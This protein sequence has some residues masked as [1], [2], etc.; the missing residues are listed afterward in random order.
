MTPAGR[1]GTISNSSLENPAL[2]LNDPKAWESILVSTAA[3]SGITV[4]H[5]GSLSLAPVWQAVSTISG[6]VAQMPLNVYR[7]LPDGQREV[8]HDH[9]AQYLMTVQPNPAMSAMEL[10]RRAMLHVL[11]WGNAYVYIRRQSRVGPPIELIN[12]LPDRVVPEWASDGTIRYKVRAGGRETVL[13][14]EEV[15]HLKGLSVENG[16]GA[17]MVSAAR[18]AIGLALAAEGFASKFFA[19]G[20]QAGGMLEVPAAMTPKA[21]ANLE[22]GFAKEYGGKANWFK[23]VILRDGAKFHQ[24]T[25][26]AQKSQLDE[27]RES[28]V[29]S[30]A[31]FFNL[32]PFKLGLADSV[33]YNSAE[34]GQ[35]VYLNGCL[36][37]WLSSN[38]GEVTIKLLTDQENRGRTHFV[39]YDK[40]SLIELDAKTQNEI[41]AI[42]RQNKIITPNEWRAK[43]NLPARTDPGGDEFENPN[44]TAGEPGTP[45]PPDSPDTPEPGAPDDATARMAQP[46]LNAQRELLADVLGRMARR[47]GHA[48]RVAAK[49][50]SK[51]MAWLCLASAEHHDVFADAARPVAGLIAAHSG[52]DVAVVVNDIGGQFFSR[53]VVGLRDA[54]VTDKPSNLAEQVDAACTEFETTIAAKLIPIILENDHED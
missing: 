43:L 9:D 23:T 32:P 13:H 47:V 3:E 48:G 50:P 25:I 8:D 21:K 27:A 49:K 46:I 14:A 29:R 42:Q 51:F 20:A 44:T 6:D 38:E 5:P 17:D 34:V 15:I 52:R 12:L 37:H 10:W 24:T 26:D 36:S 7:R 18:D 31:R 22:E 45:P 4:T 40:N 2:S 39:E 28:D 30:V 35:L 16:V 11:L 41:L 54:A 33:S 19:N 1:R 53:F